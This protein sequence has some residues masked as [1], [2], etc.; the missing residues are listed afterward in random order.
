LMSAGAAAD[1]AGSP[2]SAPPPRAGRHRRGRRGAAE[3]R[4]GRQV[5]NPAPAPPPRTGRGNTP[6]PADRAAARV[7][8][9]GPPRPASPGWPGGRPL[10]AHYLRGGDAPEQDPTSRFD[11]VPP[12]GGGRRP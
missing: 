3:R 12:R 6:T 1:E 2:A 11:A 4:T 7:R 8:L 10:A 5:P 9:T